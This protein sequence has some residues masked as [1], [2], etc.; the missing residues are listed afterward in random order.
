MTAL[1]TQSN[2]L[3]G[4][5][6]R[7]KNVL[8]ALGGKVKQLEHRPAYDPLIADKRLDH[9][10]IGVA[11]TG[12]KFAGAKFRVEVAPNF[13]HPVVEPFNGPIGILVLELH[14]DEETVAKN[15]K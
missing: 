9:V 1:P 2:R 15:K 4:H 11:G 6:D 8:V 13:A 10:G 3:V 7:A 5:R 14:F 12:N